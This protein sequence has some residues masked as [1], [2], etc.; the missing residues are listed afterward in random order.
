MPSV[1][2]SS[3]E[4]HSSLRGGRSSSPIL[5]TNNNMSTSTS[6]STRIIRRKL[7]S[8][9]RYFARYSGLRGRESV[10]RCAKLILEDDDGT[11]YTVF[12]V[13]VEMEVEIEVDIDVDVDNIDDNNN[14]SNYD[15][16]NS[17]KNDDD[18]DDDDDI[19]GCLSSLRRMDDILDV[20]EDRPVSP[21]SSSSIDYGY[22]SS[23]RRIADYGDEQ[24]ETE[25]SS[26]GIKAIQADQLPPGPN[27]V[28]V[29]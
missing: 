1:S 26:W 27:K 16:S 2:S 14:N 22:G 10:Q 21:A 11:D 3:T 19:T 29:W 5:P 9:R 6:T 15:I 28:T 23:R 17:N 13:D 12:E 24:D 4:Y 7:I 18:D 25:I 8:K 20:E